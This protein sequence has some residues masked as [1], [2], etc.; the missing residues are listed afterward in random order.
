MCA[1]MLIQMASA[2]EDIV[3]WSNVCVSRKVLMSRISF[4]VYLS[5]GIS[6]LAPKAG[7]YSLQVNSKW[8][9]RFI[10]PFKKVCTDLSYRDADIWDNDR[11]LI[12]F[13]LLRLCVYSMSTNKKLLKQG[14]PMIVI[15]KV[16]FSVLFVKLLHRGSKTNAPHPQIERV[17]HSEEIGYLAARFS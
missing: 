17:K 13:Q 4:Q 12:S 16:T 2:K 1:H 5:L 14:R 9:S 7:L 8:V 11:R 3:E 10:S 6:I 15:E